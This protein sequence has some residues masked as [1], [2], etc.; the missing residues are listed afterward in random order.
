MRILLLLLALIVSCSPLL[1]AAK[2]LQWLHV[3][4]SDS[5]QASDAWHG[6]FTASNGKAH[7]V[8][9]F[10]R[11]KNQLFS[12]SATLAV[13]RPKVSWLL[14]IALDAGYAAEL[15]QASPSLRLGFG[16]VIATS[17]ASLLS[18]R[19]DNL[20]TLGGDVHEQACY[21]KYTRAF[22]CGT[23]LAWSDYRGSSLSR[24]D[25]AQQAKLKA[26]FIYRF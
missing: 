23:G 3:Q 24:R 21:D 22:H 18:V 5:H 9:N 7:N 16:A 26:R 20:L 19:V 13:S 8:S 15:Y 12:A 1:A 2:D 25:A 14:P 4:A 6:Y 11:P 17:Q 10:Y